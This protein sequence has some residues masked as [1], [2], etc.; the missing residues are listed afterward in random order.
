[1]EINAV[2]EKDTTLNT[3]ITQLKD[4]DC[5]CEN[6]KEI[7]WSFPVVCTILLF[8]FLPLLLL[9]FSLLI[10]GLITWSIITALKPEYSGY[11]LLFFISMIGFAAGIALLPMYLGNSINCWW[12]RGIT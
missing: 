12:A 2:I 6:D 1:M 11:A 10:A 3:E 7:N 5:D 4:S 8:I 9:S